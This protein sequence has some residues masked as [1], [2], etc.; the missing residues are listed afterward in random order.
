MN[1][2][3][4]STKDLRKLRDSI[5]LELTNR[6]YNSEIKNLMLTN[7]VDMKGAEELHKIFANQ[8]ATPQS[9]E[10][11]VSEVMLIINKHTTT[12]TIREASDLW[13]YDH[14]KP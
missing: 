4:I 7:K 14:W 6:Q 11:W 5:I 3:N 9:W 2:S 1:I 13:W 10:S 12:N 8:K